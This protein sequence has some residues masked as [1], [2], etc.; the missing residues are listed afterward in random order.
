MNIT[1]LHEYNETFLDDVRIP[2]QQILGEKNRGWYVAVAA[3]EFERSGGGASIARENAIKDL[4]KILKE[5]ERNGQPLSKDPVIRQK[6]AQL[7]IEAS[8]SKY[9]GLRGLT[10]QL[11]EGRP[12]S[13]GAIGSVFGMELNQRLQEFAMEVQGPYG[14]LIRGS[15]YA[16]EQGRWQYSFLRSRAN[17]IETGTSEIKRNIIAMRVL[18][19][20]RSY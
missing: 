14:Q 16:I 4:I 5:T 1:G 6:M 11:Q 17:T 2:K 10:H 19:L 8:V 3:L 9:L 7:Y 12:G 20:P 18:G 15:K 13:E